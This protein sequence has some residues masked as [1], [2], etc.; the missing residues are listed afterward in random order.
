MDHAKIE[1]CEVENGVAF[2]DLIWHIKIEPEPPQR[3]QTIQVNISSKIDA[4]SF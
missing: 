2:R 1:T 4:D 3:S